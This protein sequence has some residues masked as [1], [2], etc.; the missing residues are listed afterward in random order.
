[1]NGDG[2]INEEVTR[3]KVPSSVPKEKVDEIINKCKSLSKSNN[4]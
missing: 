3:Q 4:L 1:M 2:T